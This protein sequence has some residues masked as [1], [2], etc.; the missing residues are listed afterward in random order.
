LHCAQC[1]DDKFDTLPDNEPNPFFHGIVDFVRFPWKLTA[2]KLLHEAIAKEKRNDPKR[3]KG[4][5]SVWVMRWKEKNPSYTW[6]QASADN[7][8]WCCTTCQKHKV[9]TVGKNKR[10]NHA[11]TANSSMKTSALTSHQEMHD[12]THLTTS[13]IQAEAFITARSTQ[14]KQATPGLLN[15]IAT[16][17]FGLQHNLSILSISHMFRNFLPALNPQVPL[18]PLNA[19]SGT[20]MYSDAKGLAAIFESISQCLNEVL[21]EKLNNSRFNAVIID[22]STDVDQKKKLIIYVQY[23]AAD[24]CTP[25]TEFCSLPSLTKGDACTVYLGTKSA[26]LN[27]KVSL[28]NFVYMGSDGASVMTGCKQ[29]VATLWK[30][31]IQPHS[32]AIHCHNHKLALGISDVNGRTPYCEV[33]DTLITKVYSLVKNSTNNRQDL[34]GFAEIFGEKYLTPKKLHKVRWLGR[35]RAVEQID[36]CKRSWLELFLT[37]PENRTAVALAKTFVT[38]EFQIRTAFFRDIHSALATLC[39]LFQTQK[40][41]LVQLD[42]IKPALQNVQDLLAQWYTGEGAPGSRRVGDREQQLLQTGKIDGVNV[43][44][45]P[46]CGESVGTDAN[47]LANVAK[48]RTFMVEYSV[49]LMTALDERFPDVGLQDAFKIFLPMSYMNVKQMYD[50]KKLHAYGKKELTVLLDHFGVP[51]TVVPEPAAFF[52]E[53]TESKFSP[54]HT[55]K[56]SVSKTFPALVVSEKAKDEFEMF[57]SH[58]FSSFAEYTEFDD[59]GQIVPLSFVEFVKRNKSSLQARFPEI[60]T[61]MQ[62][63][64]VLP[65]TSV[66]CECGFSKMKLIKSAMR[67]KMGTEVLDHLMRISCATIS[68]VDFG[69]KF[70]VKVVD[71]FFQLRNRRMSI[72]LLAGASHKLPAGERFVE[73]EMR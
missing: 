12:A 2:H 6:L 62:L 48:Q 35:V 30:K 19:K 52:S 31:H 1:V 17:F 68:C 14:V 72:A 59:K 69:I 36:E 3:F 27:K 21:V 11:L 39:C 15:L 57:K 53:E 54:F 25:L 22:E 18:T 29:G 64:L 10:Q 49:G 50:N 40:P 34:E 26:F 47:I 63:A 24:G 16:T 20:P 46:L 71:M 51:K 60:F 33:Y 37:M 66:P 13:E 7:Q 56:R 38:Y 8:G 45:E 5:F 67:S 9:T 55:S 61:L 41:H 43:E 32:T 23:L 44:L 58:M 4:D 65:L 28:D 42:Q 73:D 70:G